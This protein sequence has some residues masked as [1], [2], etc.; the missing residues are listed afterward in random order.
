MKWRPLRWW[1]FVVALLAAVRLAA[2]CA[3][4]RLCVARALRRRPHSSIG[5]ATADAGVR[6]GT[7]RAVAQATGASGGHR[8]ACAAHG[9]LSPALTSATEP[10]P[11]SDQRAGSQR[12]VAPAQHGRSS[13]GLERRWQRRRLPQAGSAAVPRPARS[14]RRAYR[15]QV[16]EWS[17]TAERYRAAVRELTS[18]D[19]WEQT[20]K[21]SDRIAGSVGGESER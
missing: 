7:H 16:A 10:R 9:L 21:V 20:L 13:H 2:R 12:P 3:A 5:P 17:V 11:A 18:V 19:S 6:S 8:Q 15:R 4:C 1:L 14:H